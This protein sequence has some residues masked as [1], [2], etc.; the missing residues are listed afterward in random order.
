MSPEPPSA[1]LASPPL[2]TESRLKTPQLQKGFSIPS[3]YVASMPISAISWFSLFSVT[4]VPF[5]KTSTRG[6]AGLCSFVHFQAASRG[7]PKK[8]EAPG[9]EQTI[10][11]PGS[12]HCAKS[13]LGLYKMKLTQDAFLA[14][15]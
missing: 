12:R 7:R 13:R 1:G 6:S 9:K 11:F 15:I 14:G 4:L 10:C 3:L 2:S 5:S 8:T